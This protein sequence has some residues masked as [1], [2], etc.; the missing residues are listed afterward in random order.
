[1]KKGPRPQYRIPGA[2]QE[3]LATAR[4]MAGASVRP[5]NQYAIDSI[6]RNAG[7]GLNFLRRGVSSGSQLLAGA[8]GVNANTNQALM[9]NAAQN[10]AF[11]FN[12]TQN[13]QDTLGRF[14]QYQEKAFYEN[15]MK[16]YQE[17]VAVKNAL[18][19]AGLQ[20]ITGGIQDFANQEMQQNF[21]DSYFGKPGQPA[22]AGKFS[23]DPKANFYPPS[24]PWGKSR[25]SWMVPPSSMGELG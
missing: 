12:A 4:S 19:G 2:A 7:T 20:N 13:L 8:Q 3:S 17:K 16:P 11:K 15:E 22:S 25:K 14:A 18:I 21:L 6:N 23:F 9:N 24:T 10:A 1:M 5:G